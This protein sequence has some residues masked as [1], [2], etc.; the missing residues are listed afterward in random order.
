MLHTCSLE[1]V[2]GGEHF[3]AGCTPV[4]CAKELVGGCAPTLLV[5]FGFAVPTCVA[6]TTPRT[7]N[8]GSRTPHHAPRTLSRAHHTTHLEL[9]RAH[10]TPRTSN[11]GSR[12][13]HHAPPTLARA[14]HATHLE[15]WLVH[16]TPRISNF[17]SRTPRHAPRPSTL[18]CIGHAA[19]VLAW[20]G[21]HHVLVV[22]VLFLLAAGRRP[23]ARSTQPRAVVTEYLANRAP[24]L[25]DKGW[26]LNTALVEASGSHSARVTVGSSRRA[27]ATLQRK[28]RPGDW[29]GRVSA[30]AQ[31]LPKHQ[32]H[33]ITLG[34][35]HAWPHCA[36][37]ALSCVWWL[38]CV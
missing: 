4:M 20:L 36:Q 7:S 38:R 25:H 26:A 14:R 33:A 37:R 31:G 1:D 22:G 11:S 10:T 15:L 5:A 13:P 19:R 17:G 6:R 29:M 12:T 23:D 28:S 3:V 34:V 8:F 27:I 32:I 21:A 30:E 2:F 24:R 16:T 35:L 18:G 9:W